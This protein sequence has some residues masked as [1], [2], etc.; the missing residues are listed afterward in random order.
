MLNRF[1][2]EPLAVIVAWLIMCKVFNFSSLVLLNLLTYHHFSVKQ[3]YIEKVL[4][5][6]RKCAFWKYKC[7]TEPS[8]RNVIQ[9]CFSLS[10]F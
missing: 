8:F 6:E 5:P 7:K 1:S 2:L 3:S 10:Q 9:V 4:Q